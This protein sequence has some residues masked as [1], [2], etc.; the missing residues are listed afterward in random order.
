MV[1][2]ATILPVSGQH[3]ESFAQ[4]VMLS[5][6]TTNPAIILDPDQ[7]SMWSWENQQS[8]TLV[9]V[10]NE[11]NDAN[12]IID[13]LNNLIALDEIDFIIFTAPILSQLITVMTNKIGTINP[14]IALLMPYGYP[15]SFPLRLDS[16]LFI[17]KFSGGS[18]ALFE[19]YY[20]RLDKVRNYEVLW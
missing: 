9:A 14:K 7:K 5:L 4:D 8:A 19:K 15:V 1:S 18:A 16:R 12:V 3:L 2:M 10:P 13:H 17:Y 20:I 6:G 11:P